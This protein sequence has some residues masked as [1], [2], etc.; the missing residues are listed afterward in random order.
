MK[1]VAIYERVSTLHQ[2]EDGYSIGEQEERLRMFASA[3]RWIVTEVYSDP[4]FSGGK[5][6]R[7]A[8]QKLI[9]DA[10]AH[11]FDAVIV[12]KLD[13]LSRSQKDTLYLIEDV[14]NPNDIGL[15]S[16]MEN[17][18]T[19]TSFGKAMIGIL[20]VFAQLERGQITE[21]MTMGRIG[22][23]KAGYFSGGSKAPIGYTYVK[24]DAHDKKTLQ[25][26]EYEAMQV[27]EVYRLFL[28]EDYTF[29]EIQN[30][31]HEHYT[32]KYGDWSFVSAVSR[33]LRSRIYI[34]E[35][36]FS[37]TWYPGI[38]EPIIDRAEFDS[39]QE[40][41]D[42]YMLTSA[43]KM[44]DNFK[45]AH[46]LTG[47]LRCGLCGGRYFLKS[48]KH[49]L[50]NGEVHYF[51]KY[52]CYTAT[53]QAKD[54]TAGKTCNNVSF[55]M[56]ELENKVTDEI[57][58][59]ALDPGLIRAISEKGAAGKGKD[60]RAN[61]LQ[62]RLDDLARQEDRLVDLYQIG[63]LDIDSIRKRSDAIR[64]ERDKIRKE[65][66]KEEKE[67]KITMTADEA[68]RKIGAFDE[69]FEHGTM[70]EK[71]AF[72]RALIDEIV[73]FPDRIEIHWSFETK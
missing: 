32:T 44:A 57:R 4:G 28:H 23:A 19:T 51:R 49:T 72:I 13:R 27:R 35:V 47:M 2:K 30:Y 12:Y 69:V 20:S 67:V 56:S 31:M 8:M 39:V 54:R 64:E 16:L 15:I 65:M 5:L 45:G 52:S 70:D 46:L 36:S 71:R 38:H 48:Y 37:G 9:K 66:A 43:G 34:G 17:F 29:K 14:F 3:H 73:I 26:D 41:Y 7:P 63:S 10:K 6:D 58:K 42:K 50:K 18:D 68:I 62:A 33:M 11:Q 24:G 60:D 53:G 55:E 61:G 59:L 40:K 1:T 22:R 25:V 21:R